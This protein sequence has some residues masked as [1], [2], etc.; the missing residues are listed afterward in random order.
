MS[1][2]ALNTGHIHPS[3]IIDPSAYID[4][5]AVIGPYV[6]VGPDCVVGAGVNLHPH[7]VLVKNT[8]LGEGCIVHAHACLGD[9]PQDLGYKGQRTHLKVGAHTTLRE[10]V[11]LHRASVEGGATR[12]GQHCLLMASAHAGHDVVVEDHV[13]I[14]N[15]SLLAGHVTVGRHAFISGLCAVHQHTAIGAY[16]ILGGVSGARQDIPPFCKASGAIAYLAGLNSVG[17]RRNGI[18]SSS[19]LALKRAY[20]LLWRS[21]L[22]LSE[23]ITTI[24][25]SDDGPDPYVKELTDFIK[26]SKRGVVRHLHRIS[27]KRF[28]ADDAIVAESEE[29]SGLL[30]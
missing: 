14:A 10:F 15:G 30:C 7:V 21:H 11:T 4:P 13:V 25:A 12:I 18:E 20:N 22:S 17:L 6:V 26:V 1:S 23:A 28:D 16:S 9:D 5:T 8:E 2:S 19:R 27:M 24:N 3:A 29:E